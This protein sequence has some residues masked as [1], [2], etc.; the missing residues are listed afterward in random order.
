M[1]VCFGRVS[2]GDEER[3]AEDLRRACHAPAL[4]GVGWEPLLLLAE[5]RGERRAQNRQNESSMDH[6]SSPHTRIKNWESSRTKGDIAS[7][8]V[9]ITSS[10]M[11][12]GRA[13]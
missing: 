2:A 10:V 6:A 11:I 13:S 1:R 9:Q 12:S 7:V 4:G 3:G 8:G 5:R